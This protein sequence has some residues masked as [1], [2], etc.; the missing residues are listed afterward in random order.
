M[1]CQFILLKITKDHDSVKFY[2]CV[3][4]FLNLEDIVYRN[5]PNK[6]S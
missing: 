3:Y 4:K 5:I 6:D 2:N 1:T